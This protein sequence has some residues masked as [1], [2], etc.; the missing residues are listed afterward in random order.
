MVAYTVYALCLLLLRIRGHFGDTSN[1]SA[2]NNEGN[3][4]I[5]K[6]LSSEMDPAEIRLIR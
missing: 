1:L 6:V 2:H 3:S 4:C 5:L